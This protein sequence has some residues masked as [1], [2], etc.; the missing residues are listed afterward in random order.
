MCNSIKAKGILIYTIGFQLSATAHNENLPKNCA[1]RPDMYYNEQLAS[2]FKDIT[3]GLGELRIAGKRSKAVGKRRRTDLT[4]PVCRPEPS[5][6]QSLRLSLDLFAD[7]FSVTRLS[8]MA[9]GVSIGRAIE[10]LTFRSS[11]QRCGT[12]SPAGSFKD[13]PAIVLLGDRDEVRFAE[14][15][16]GKYD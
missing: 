13:S 9:S 12:A 3:Q 8:P 5:F 15:F 1:T 4:R 14:R 2:V 10:R 11:E 7:R 16:S 6:A